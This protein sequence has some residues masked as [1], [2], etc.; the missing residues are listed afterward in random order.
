MGELSGV[1]PDALL[2]A[3][4][5]CSRGSVAEGV[6]YFAPQTTISLN[7]VGL[8]TVLNSVSASVLKFIDRT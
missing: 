1:V 8:S 2:F 6:F 4:E 7:P 5:V 3:F